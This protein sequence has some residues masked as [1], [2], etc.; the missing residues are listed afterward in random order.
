MRRSR[1]HFT[2]RLK[3]IAKKID[4]NAA[5]IYE[6]VWSPGAPI[7][8]KINRTL[9]KVKNLWVYGSWAR[10]C[11]ECSDLD[12]FCELEIVGGH[13]FPDPA[14]V[15]TLLIQSVQDI[16]FTLAEERLT[17]KMAEVIKD[18]IIIW[19]QSNRNWEQ[20]I[21]SIKAD[22]SA[23]RFQRP[24]DDLPLRK[25]QLFD[26]VD[27]LNVIAGLQKDGVIESSIVLYEDL[28]PDQS[29]WSQSAINWFNAIINS[30]G[31]KTVKT[32]SFVFEFFEREEKIKEFSHYDSPRYQIND[33]HIE[34]GKM[35]AYRAIRYLDDTSCRG[36]MLAPHSSRRGP[37]GIWIIRRGPKHPQTEH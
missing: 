10:G 33:W 24:Y 28:P 29:H 27:T 30:D 11:L 2:K 19:S 3:K 17:R 16:D 12:L 36:I 31:K 23:T 35:S 15:K 6:V 9:F 1:D 13:P 20:N 22:P 18:K 5:V 26:N 37:N 14:K 21:D 4:E 7:A 25:E 8:D 34:V 32:M